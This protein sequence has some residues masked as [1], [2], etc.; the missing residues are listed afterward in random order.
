LPATR[1]DL[2]GRRGIGS[3]LP[4]LGA[5]AVGGALGAGLANRV[6]DRPAASLPGLG[7]QAS[8]LPA[9]PSIGDRRDSL[10]DRLTGEGRPSQLPAGDRETARGDRQQNRDDRQTN[11]Q[12]RREEGV[13]NREERQQNRDE[14]QTT[15]QEDRGT[16]QGTRDE[17]QANRQDNRGGR[18]ED[19]TDRQETRQENRAN[20]QE[21]RQ[22]NWE[23]VRNDWQENRDQIRED[24]QNYRDDA[25]EDWQGWLDDHY[26]W[27]GGWYGGYA[28]GYWGNWDYLW[29]A[30]PVAAAA[31]L[32]WWGANALGYGF[33]YSDYSNPYYTDS[34]PAYY[35]EP[36]ISVAVEPVPE[37]APEGALP[38]G[39]SSEAVSRF[40]EARAAFLAGQY[41][42]ALKLT[43][44]AVAQMP[45]DAVLHEFRSL[46]LF[47]LG[48]YAEAAATIH[49]VLN[50]GPGWDW[51]TLSG[52]YSST[53][54]YTQQLRA[55]EAA[56]KNA[57]QA[58]D[59]RFLLG[60]HYLSCGFP[61]Q[62]LTEFR[63]AQAERPNDSV[64][65][66]LVAT[67]GP[68]DGQPAQTPAAETP[69]AIPAESVVGKW[70]APG[71]GNSKY[72]MS[73]NKDGSFTWGF[74]K[75]ARKQEVKGVHTVEGNVLALE[76]DSGGVLLAEL[77]QKDPDTLH[78]KMIGGKADDPG[79]EFRREPAK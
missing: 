51:K 41:D 68:R 67:L 4:A 55:L 2:G 35:S 54:T 11:R 49:P 40:D 30:H 6:G 5:G 74:A 16:R 17:R 79:L 56:C 69:K 47:A 63:K 38:P 66:S 36:I 43:D 7:D 46:V 37:T 77:T 42:A 76:P 58:A 33:G 9:N 22:Q 3:T 27:Y 28:S 61:E 1:P 72:S 60:Y 75:G 71:K 48:R 26:G 15:R 18:Q 19:R 14:R 34:M 13:P 39:V 31:G 20:R 45:H 53:D 50:V 12:E 29:D 57:P 23:D 64:S 21:N 44:A 73:L 32:T 10:H 65:A 62:A 8:Q 78:F 25:R 59:L 70:T 52:L 24:W